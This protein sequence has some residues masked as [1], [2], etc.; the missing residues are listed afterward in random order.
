MP[1]EPASLRLAS[2][3]REAKHYAALVLIALAA[4]IKQWPSKG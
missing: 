4:I 3:I 2:A 1:R